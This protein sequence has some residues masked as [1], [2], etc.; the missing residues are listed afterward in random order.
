MSDSSE[1]AA[2]LTS[3]LERL[4]TERV[5]RAMVRA[6]EAG[7]WQERLWQECEALGLPMLLVPEE[8]GGVGLGWSAAHDL[9]KLLGRFC[10][11]L[12]L[13]ETILAARLLADSG[14]AVPPGPLTIASGDGISRA[15]GALS[16][17]LKAVPYARHA[18]HVVVVKRDGP[19]HALFCVA[20]EPL[21]VR[22][23]ANIGR[24]PRDEVLLDT[25]TVVGSGTVTAG[26]ENLAVSLGASLRASQIAGA[27][28]AV[29]TMSIEYANLRVQFGRPIG[30]FQAVQQSLA[31]LACEAAA[32]DVAAAMAAHARDCGED[33]GFETAVAKIRSGEA[34]GVGAALAHQTHG[35]IGF[36]DEYTLHDLTRRLWSWRSEFGSERYWA[37]ALGRRALAAGGEL[38][39]LITSPAKIVIPT[40]AERMN[41]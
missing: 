12:P 1:L 28:D 19:S 37:G 39:H 38:W 11:P 7:A 36:T 17:A 25:L 27:L 20:L 10:V 30:K 15:A 41:G 32:A 3:Q 18:G 16:G 13:G 34:A 31:L 24:E 4:F 26:D 22:S 33:G 6:A 8:A 21:A 35:A 9:F 29:R 5:D 2:I 40:T 14:L 23:G